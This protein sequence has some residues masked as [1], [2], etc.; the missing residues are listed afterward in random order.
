MSL[1]QKSWLEIA[2]LGTGLLLAVFGGGG[3]LRVL[4]VLLMA[5]G[6]VLDFAWNRCPHCGGW[7][8]R[9]PGKYC[10]SCGEK[11]DFDARG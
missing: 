8:G 1:K 9:Y 4:G 10:K 6:F 5:A 2:V 3:I 11:I 7:L